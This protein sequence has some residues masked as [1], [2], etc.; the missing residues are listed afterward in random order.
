M[1]LLALGLGREIFRGS[2]REGGRDAGDAAGHRDQPRVPE[3]QRQAGQRAGQ[4]DQRVVQ[5]Q[6]DGTDVPQPLLVDHVQQGLLMRGLVVP[7]RLRLADG[8]RQFSIG[9][10]GAV[11]AALHELGAEGEAQQTADPDVAPDL[12][13]VGRDRLAGMSLPQFG[14]PFLV[15]RDPLQNVAVVGIP[16]AGRQLQVDVMLRDFRK[17]MLP[18]D[19]AHTFIHGVSSPLLG[20]RSEHRLAGANNRS[21]TRRGHQAGDAPTALAAGT[22]MNFAVAFA[23]IAPSWVNSA[24]RQWSGPCESTSQALTT[25]GVSTSTGARKRTFNSPV[26]PTWP[27]AKRQWV[28]A[29]SSSAEITP[30]CR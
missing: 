20:Q 23:L 12:A 17:L 28:M 18:E 19:G 5:A 9:L 4:F 1:L 8:R 30:P 13:P 27:R 2:H 7:D 10:L 3:R 29:L 15:G 11:L 25:A 6:H 26:I 21:G 16:L 24:R 14:V 22:S